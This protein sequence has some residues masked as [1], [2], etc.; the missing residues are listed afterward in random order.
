MSAPLAALMARRLCHDF[1][2]PAG[3]IGTAIDML[4]DEG[5]PE[6]LSLTSDSAAAL[7]AALELYR[8]VLTPSADPVGGGRARQ[9][10]A[11][12]LATRGGPGLDWP[13]DA[14]AWPPGFAALTAGL[15]MVA[16]EAA[17]R[18]ATLRVEDGAVAIDNTILPAEVIV[19]LTGGPA[20]TTRAALAGVLAAQAASTGIELAVEAGDPLRLVASYQSSRLPR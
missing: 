15:A 3:A 6:L 2:G 8:Y 11:G 14:E 13:D 1:A 4:G 5:D 9:L 20:T 19:A 18:T 16:A 17:A 7:T 12:W 10:L